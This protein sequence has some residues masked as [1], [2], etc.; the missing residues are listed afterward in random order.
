LFEQRSKAMMLSSYR[1]WI[2]RALLGPACLFVGAGG[3]L[4][5]ANPPPHENRILEMLTNYHTVPD[6]Y[7]IVK[8]LTSGEKLE[9]AAAASFSPAAMISAGLYTGFGPG[10]T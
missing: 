5:Q 10:P 8:P 1:G 7:E 6:R 4:A 3:L 2:S 9:L